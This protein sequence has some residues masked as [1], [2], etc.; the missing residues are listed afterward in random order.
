MN[1]VYTVFLEKDYMLLNSN[2]IKY[3]SLVPYFG[4][5]LKVSLLFHNVMIYSIK[6]AFLCSN[7]ICQDF[8]LVNLVPVLMLPISCLFCFYCQKLFRNRPIVIHLSA[9]P[10]SHSGVGLT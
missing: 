2:T 6:I 4:E 10:P 9:K 7:G 5:M 8:G 3:Q 1:T